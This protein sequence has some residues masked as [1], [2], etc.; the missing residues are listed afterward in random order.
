MQQNNKNIAEMRNVSIEHGCLPTPFFLML[1]V[2]KPEKTI[3]IQENGGIHTQLSIVRVVHSSK[4]NLT[5]S[6]L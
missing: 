2:L 4:P 3:T 1:Q 6:E 5:M